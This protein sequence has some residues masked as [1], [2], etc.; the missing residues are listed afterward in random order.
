MAVAG[1]DEHLAEVSDAVCRMGSL[2]LSSGTGSFRVK[3]AMGRVASAL[4]VEQLEAQVSLNEIVVTTR[5][6]GVFRTQV[7]EV[8][9]PSVNADRISRLLNVSL[10]ARPGWSA[11][12]LHRELDRVEAT[13]NRYR[14]WVVVL[15]A[16]L[17]CAAFAFLN[18]GRWQECLAAGLAAAIGKGVQ[19]A[20]HHRVR[21]NLLAI[22]AVSATVAC[23]VYLLIALAIEH[24]LPWEGLAM[25]E[26]AFTSA[27]LFLVP[28][29]PLMT[30]ALDL[31]RF[32]FTSG[33]ARLLFAGLILFSASMGAWLVAWAF[34]LT[35]GEI[36]RPDLAPWLLVLLWAVTSF[37]GVLGFAWTFQTP[38]RVALV[39]AVIGMLANVGRLVALEYGLNQLIGA[40]LAS[41]VI[42]LLAAS[43]SQL[44]LAPRII[45][46]VPAVLIMVP[47]ASSYRALVYMINND[48]LNALANASVAM[49]VIVAL[50]AGLALARML[51]D[52]AWIASTPSWTDMPRTRAQ[53]VLRAHDAAG[54]RGSADRQ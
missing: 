22:V 53:R 26:A 16:A 34:R 45:L 15:G 29:F 21:I 31:T 40:A 35:P 2:M 19:L 33:V 23:S 6:R 18:N 30:A 20:L 4:G 43:V 10:R 28:G 7:V 47:G 12:D 25:H 51:T 14:W 50:A 9:A 11:A 49:G 38:P 1:R 54:G 39:T 27:I 8:P 36:S 5:A 24:L 17:A 3:A 44:L 52:P 13:G 46:S 42:G 32:D 48:P 41:A 37:A